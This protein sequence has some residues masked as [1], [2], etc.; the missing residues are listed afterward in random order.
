MFTFAR[1]AKPGEVRADG[2]GEFNGARNGFRAFWL[3]D[4]FSNNA[5]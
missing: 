3:R 5:G 2:W 1:D 4:D